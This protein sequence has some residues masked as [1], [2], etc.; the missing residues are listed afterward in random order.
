ML[1]FFF[2]Y[3]ILLLFNVLVEL[4]SLIPMEWIP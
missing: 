3:F 4:F 1:F 2:S